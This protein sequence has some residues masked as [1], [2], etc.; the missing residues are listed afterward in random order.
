MR[1]RTFGRALGIGV[2]FAGRALLEGKP[3]PGAESHSAAR[4]DTAAAQAAVEAAGARGRA[5]GLGAGRSARNVS[6]GGRSFARAVWNPF[7]LATGVLWLEITGMFFGL[8]GLFFVQHL[9]QLRGAWRSGPQH[10]RLLPYA[11]L[12]VLFLYFSASS[13]VRAR[14]K[15]RAGR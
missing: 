6:R 1:S 11:A 12:A 8:F 7:A 10:G 15:Q 3:A 4:R 14:R 13:F 9:Y 5:V 2:R